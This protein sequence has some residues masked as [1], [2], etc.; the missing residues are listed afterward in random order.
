MKTTLY[1][2]CFCLFFSL[3]LFSVEDNA[4][5]NEE[6][7]RTLQEMEEIQEEMQDILNEMDEIIKNSPDKKTH[8]PKQSS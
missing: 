1:I 2:L 3:P 6:Y 5:E 4:Q 8:P 7:D